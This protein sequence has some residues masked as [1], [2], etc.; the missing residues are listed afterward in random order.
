MGST[1]LLLLNFIVA[2]S[3]LIRNNTIIC[4]EDRDEYCYW[5]TDLSCIDNLGMC[6]ITCNASSACWNSIINCGDGNNCNIL[7]AQSDACAYATINCANSNICHITCNACHDSTINCPQ[8]DDCS[9]KLYDNARGVIHCPTRGKCSMECTRCAYTNI[10]C[11]NTGQCQLYCNRLSNDN[12]NIAGCKGSIIT[13]PENGN[14]DIWCGYSSCESATILCPIN[15]DCTLHCSHWRAC[16]YVT[17]DARNSHMLSIKGCFA[18]TDICKNMAIWCPPNFNGQ[19]RCFIQGD[20]SLYGDFSDNTVQ[21]SLVFYAINSWKDINFDAYF[22]NLFGKYSTMHCG[23]NYSEACNISDAA[24][25]CIDESSICNVPTAEPTPMPT[26]WPGLLF[27]Y[28]TMSPNIPTAE[29]VIHSPSF[30]S[31]TI[32]PTMSIITTDTNNNKMDYMP[33]E[34]QIDDNGT[35][36]ILLILLCILVFL[37]IVTVVVLYVHWKCFGNDEKE[38]SIEMINVNTTDNNIEKQQLLTTNS[39]TEQQVANPTDIVN[40]TDNNIERKQQLTTNFTNKQQVANPN[41]EQQ[42]LTIKSKNIDDTTDISAMIS[43]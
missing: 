3:V 14:C 27:I 1:M 13:C 25:R 16:I 40:T 2:G 37:V 23:N 32:Q 36:L 29:Q 42:P 9:L 43:H 22:G 10:H 8:N 28:P 11:P 12:N 33:Q 15:G 4:N 19:K 18:G 24:W 7:C 39:T 17:I 41:D 30:L 34:P 21:H 31:T 6:S 38:T 5:N 26:K 35:M 20:N